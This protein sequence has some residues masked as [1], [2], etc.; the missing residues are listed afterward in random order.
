M[1]NTYQLGMVVQSDYLH[2]SRSLVAMAGT[3]AS[4]YKGLSPVTLARDLTLDLGLF[5]V[6][7]VREQL[8][9]RRRSWL[10]LGREPGQG[11]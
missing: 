11:H 5:P 2:L 1:S 8:R 6:N 3:Y 10:A 7:L 4:L 9:A